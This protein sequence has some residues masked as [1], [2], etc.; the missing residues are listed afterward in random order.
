[1]ATRKRK[2]VEYPPIGVLNH[3]HLTAKQYNGQLALTIRGCET[4]D[5]ACDG[6]DR[7]TATL[8]RD[9]AEQLAWVIADYLATSGPNP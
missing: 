2:P 9:G 4:E 3:H 1:M 8:T 7:D 5:A 6:Q